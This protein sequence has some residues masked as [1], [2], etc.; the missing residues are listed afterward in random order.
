MCFRSQYHNKARNMHTDKESIYDIISRYLGGD[1]SDQEASR[2]RRWLSEDRK[3]QIEFD[4]IAALW[5]KSQSLQFPE[6]INTHKALTTVHTKGKIKRIKTYRLS[7]MQQIAA[8][9]VISILLT[10]LYHYFSAGDRGA[11]Y[12]TDYYQEVSAAYGTRTNVDLPDGTTVILNSG[13][14]L[15]FSSLFSKD[16]TRRVE[17]RG[18]GY[19][20]VAKDTERPF[21]VNAGRIDIK[22][23]GTQFNV[24]AYGVEPDID[25]VLV[26][27]EV[28]IGEANSKFSDNIMMLEP[29]QLARFNT[30]ESKI[31][32]ETSVTLEKHIGWVEGR[33]IFEDDPIRT[34]VS[35]LEKW[36]GV[37]VKL[38]GE[39][40]LNYRFTGTFVNESLEG[41]LDA[42][43]LTSP[44]TYDIKPATK[45][46]TGE[47]TRKIITLK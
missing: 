21:I 33:L 46:R 22:V 43:S 6:R 30:A 36:Y 28:A 8:I 17:L 7:L 5:E 44:L 42:F 11:M 4:D 15:R 31:Y 16:D 10:G 37:D 1:A 38:D 29:N 32:K 3:N 35:R 34:V 18:E 23:L 40:L 47:Y 25:I 13:S 41:V 14:S 9:L 39:N 2:L 24:N 19:F 20:E 45:D 12:E 27:G 26:E